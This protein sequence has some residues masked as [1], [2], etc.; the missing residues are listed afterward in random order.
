[1]VDTLNQT[2]RGVRPESRFEFWR[3][4]IL[5]NVEVSD[6][7]GFARAAFGASRW[8]AR[9]PHGSV[10]STVSQPVVIRRSPRHVG[11]DGVDAVC[12]QTLTAGAGF[13]EQYGRSAVIKPG[14]I[15]I[16]DLGRPLTQAGA[17]PYEELRLYLPRSVFNAHVGGL[18]RLAGRVFAAGD[19]L[20]DMAVAY[21][22]ASA[23]ALPRM[24]DAQAQIMFEGVVHLL[25]G[26][27]SSTNPT[28]AE[29]ETSEAA[30]RSVADAY[31]ARRLHDPALGVSEV[32]AALAVSRSRLYAAFS[33]TGGVQAAIRDARLDRA[34]GLLS[35]PAGER[36]TVVSI[37]LACGFPDH[38]SFG[39]AFR[40]RFGLTP[41]DVLAGLAAETA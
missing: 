30:L 7:P 16:C 8:L 4:T 25:R 26:I 9:T 32:L 2:T 38:S 27:A 19:P 20:V 33:E 13:Q 31:I 35:A 28:R 15:M 39:H 23:D 41:R 34:H 3:D 12:I 18:E 5:S 10:I 37:A 22:R 6:M 1:M 40:R 14:G 36:R 21:L 24:S 11:H 17:E 29:T